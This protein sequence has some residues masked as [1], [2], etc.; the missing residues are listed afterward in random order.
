MQTLKNGKAPEI[1]QI[2]AEL[3]KVDTESTCAELGHLFDLIWR[4]EAAEAV[5]TGPDI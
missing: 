1:D 4:E 5:K 3:L 2:T